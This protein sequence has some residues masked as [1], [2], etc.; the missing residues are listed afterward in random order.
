[1]TNADNELVRVSIRGLSAEGFKR[2]ANGEEITLTIKGTV[3]EYKESS[4]AHEGQRQ[5]MTVKLERCVEGVS[6]S[7]H[8]A[9]EGQMSLADVEP[10]EEEGFDDDAADAADTGDGE[11]P[12]DDE[13]G[14][15]Y[16][17]FSGE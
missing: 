9:G 6:E 15:D 10:D 14:H 5:T 17:V 11:E 4:Q 1:M 8:E 3:V 13:D 16:S 7:V 12:D 2:R